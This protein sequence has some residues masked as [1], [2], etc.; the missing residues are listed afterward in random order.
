[1]RIEYRWLSSLLVG[2]LAL[3]GPFA[4]TARAQVPIHGFTGTIAL[5]W[6]VDQFYTGVNKGLSEASDGIERLTRSRP[7]D[8]RE[9]PTLENLRPGM[10]VVVLYTVKGIQASSDQLN[11]GRV[12]SV[13]RRN[14]RIAVQFPDGSTKAL[15]VSQHDARHENHMQSHSRVVVYYTDESGRRVANYFKQADQ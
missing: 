6:N 2:S 7:P 11:E 12:T 15:R 1:M 8:H 14:G 4:S 13:D 3:I 10:P 9:A 5:P